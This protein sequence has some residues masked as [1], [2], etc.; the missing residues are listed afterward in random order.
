MKAA[1]I[2]SWLMCCIRS[3]VGFR[4]L[5]PRAICASVSKAV[6]VAAKTLD[7]EHAS[8]V[9]MNSTRSPRACRAAMK[10]AY[11]VAPNAMVSS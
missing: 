11:S 7:R 3:L 9:C 5:K 8:P 2:E 10:S 4:V 6:E 1:R